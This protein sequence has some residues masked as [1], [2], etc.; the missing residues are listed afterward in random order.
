MKNSYKIALLAALGFASVSVA[1]A[2]ININDDDLVLGITSSSQDYVIDL[3]Q[4]PATA[5]TSLGSYDLSS[6]DAA[7][8]S[9]GVVGG[10]TDG[11]YDVA[12]G[13]D[14]LFLTKVRSGTAA[15]SYAVAGTESAPNL[16][17]Q[18]N[19]DASA[20]LVYAIAT[21]ITPTSTTG[22]N[23]WSQIVAQSSTAVG[24]SG[25]GNIGAYAGNPMGALTSPLTLDL[26]AASDDN[27]PNSFNYLGDIQLTETGSSVSVVFDPASV[28]VPEPSTYGLIA[29]A[30]LLAVSLRNKLSRKNA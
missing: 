23:A 18:N 15:T 14:S 4:I 22:H 30:G 17:S 29:G 13:G 9:A 2:Q 1:Q 11:A 28:A 26:W 5:N 6:F 3:G 8:L 10:D 20:G 19:L 24:S 7:S 21:G 25:G 16:I 12:G 27:E